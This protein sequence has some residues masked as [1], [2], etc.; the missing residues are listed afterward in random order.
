MR[1]VWPH[2]F[3]KY[4]VLPC[5]A[6]AYARF[7][8]PIDREA[9]PVMAQTPRWTFRL[10]VHACMALQPSSYQ[11]NYCPIAFM[12][13]V[14]DEMHMQGRASQLGEEGLGSHTCFCPM[15]AHEDELGPY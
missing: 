2:V 13:F 9:Q 5:N 1:K 10:D 15:S 11:T 3:D 6:L 12:V 4:L 8:L 14:D 7:G